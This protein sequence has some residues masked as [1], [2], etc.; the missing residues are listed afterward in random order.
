[1]LHEIKV[2]KSYANA[3]IEGR[4]NFEVRFNDRGYNAGDQVKFKVYDGIY[5]EYTHP[6]DGR[7]Y[8]VTYVQSGLGLK[9]DYVVFGIKVGS[10]PYKESED[11]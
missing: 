11:Q 4:K 2:Y 5:R 1:M 9:K 10:V 7:I 8:D 6:L 3:I